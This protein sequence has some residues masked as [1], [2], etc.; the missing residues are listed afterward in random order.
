LHERAPLWGWLRRKV[1][2]SLFHLFGKMTGTDDGRAI[3]TDGLRGLLPGSPAALELGAGC[4]ETPYPELG[5]P[6]AS[7]SAAGRADVIF[8]TGRFRS[9]STLLWNLFRHIPG[10]TAYYE[11]LNERRWFDPS[12]RGD[13]TDPTHRH[14]EAYWKE[15]DGLKVLGAHYREAWTER[16][17]LMDEGFWEPDLKR[18]VEILIEWAAG[19]PVLQF[20]RIDFRLP[21]F[22]RHF[23]RARLVHLYRH[24]RDQWCSTL[25]DP[26]AFPKER[27]F[28]DF[29]PHDHYYLRNWAR[30]L[31]YHFPFLEESGLRHPYQMFYYVWKLSYLFGRKY[32]HHSLAFED[33]IADP[34]ARIPALLDALDVRGYDL[35][36][37][38]RLVAQPGSSKWRAYADDAWFR[39][40]EA[41]CDRV[42]SEY[43]GIV[44]E[45]A[46][47]PVTQQNGS[48]EIQPVVPAGALPTTR[49]HQW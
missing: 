1:R 2:G 7:Q 36:Q 15:Y 49:R 47:A 3:L 13:H 41:E 23:P 20:N 46:P 45:P 33:L 11:P 32:A 30:D 42:L 38:K 25:R 4:M 27:G 31:R 18:Y 34:D 37:L 19:R 9:G 21:W 29:G 43:F 39:D 35:D 8:I 26:A 12:R 40:Y 17:L 16:H 44:A 28:A 6:G 14:A 10:C 22:R 5:Q 24:P 48:L